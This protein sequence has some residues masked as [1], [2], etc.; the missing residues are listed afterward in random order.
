MQTPI[1]NF[2]KHTILVVDDEPDIREI[3]KYNLEEAGYNVLTANDGQAAL[4][5]AK[6]QNETNKIDLILLDVMMPN[7]DGEQT[8]RLL[9]KL[10][11]IQQAYVIFLTARNE[12]YCEVAC[13][14]AGADDF[15]TKPIK[16][17]KLLARIK[18][19][20]RRS[21]LDQQ[22]VKESKIFGDIEISLSDRKV[23][24][25]K[26]EIEFAP[27]EYEILLLLASRE[28]K[29]F[30]RNDIIDKVWGRG[31]IVVDRTIDVHIAKLRKKLGDG[32]IVNITAV[33]FKFV[34]HT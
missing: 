19:V 6:N 34:S 2:N 14:D 27:K 30:S 15:I 5:L 17:K 7:V 31:V 24:K 21:L 28:G 11:D 12:E 25:N 3:L 33:G 23:Y 20:F 13:F 32:Y 26:Q 22:D 16:P 29:V 4:E 18:A 10:P 8:C 1:E 9:R